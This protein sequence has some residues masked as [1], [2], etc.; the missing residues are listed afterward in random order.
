M[1]AYKHTNRRGDVYLLQVGKTRTGKPRYYFGRK[2]T[3]EPVTEIPAGYEVFELPQRGQ[4]FLRRFRPSCIAPLE[5]E[6]V[7]EGI[8]D[9]SN[10]AHFVVDVEDD[11]LV[12][13]LPTMSINK[14]SDLIRDLAGPDALQV[15]RFREARDQ[16]VRESEHEKVM[17]FQLLNEEQR[18]FH[19][20]R[21]CFRSSLDCWMHLAG[22]A[23][24][25]DLVEEY[26]EHLGEESFYE[27]F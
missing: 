24:L 12:V 27:L 19:V 11:S 4:V 1:L 18:L 5:C 25:P 15:H 14:V 16:M 21:W 6:I 3:G 22:P 23:P 8:R 7:A 2:L 26:V 13:Y 20:E 17:R 9:L 10:V